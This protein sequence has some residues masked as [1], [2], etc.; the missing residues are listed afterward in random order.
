MKWDGIRAIALVCG[1]GAARLLTRNGND[2]TASY[3]EVVAGL[4]AAARGDASKSDGSNGSGSSIVLD[5]EIVALDRTGRPKF[6]LL[7]SR[8]NLGAAEARAA[9]SRVPVH[10]LRFDLLEQNGRSLR[11]E[12]YDTRRRALETLLAPTIGPDRA[13]A[14]AAAAAQLQVPPALDGDFAAALRTSKD[15]GLGLEGIVAKR[16]DAP[17]SAGRRSRSWIK[18]KHTLTQEVVIGG[19]R[20][21]AGSRADTVGALL[22]GVPG[23]G[24]PDGGG[25]PGQGL[26]DVG[27]VGTGLSE[28]QLATALALLMPLRAPESPFQSIPRLDARD[29]R[30]VR[31]VLVGEVE[32][33][34]W[35]AAGR[36][37]HP[38]WRGW[39]TDKA[40]ADVRVEPGP[41]EP[42][43]TASDTGA[44]AG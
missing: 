26:V 25:L 11:D 12:S 39:R 35:T 42:D 6:G 30:W 19:W 33:G 9:T 10:Y 40:P 13:A 37:R 18:V 22:L 34:E 31:P 16:R 36:L 24:E 21:G 23:R 17:Y 8:M 43:A 28:R 29:A 4:A 3:P 2:V 14:A 1:D 15:L 44:G 38:S 32:F 20:P 5:G 7:Q 41:V 27:R